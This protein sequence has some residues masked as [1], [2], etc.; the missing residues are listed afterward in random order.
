M[1]ED[2]RLEQLRRRYPGWVIWRG[3]TTAAYW[4]MPPRDH[5]SQRELISAPDLDELERR[6]AQ[7]QQPGRPE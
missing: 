6:L 1:P 2:A 7:A 3:R 5:P 4:A